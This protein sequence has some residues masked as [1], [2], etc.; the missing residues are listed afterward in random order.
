MVIEIV[1]KFTGSLKYL[2][3]APDKKTY[4]RVESFQKRK[5]TGKKIENEK[6]R[7]KSEDFVAR[8]E[9]I[10]SRPCR[11]LI[12]LVHHIISP[13]VIIELNVKCDLYI[14]VCHRCQDILVKCS[15]RAKI[16]TCIVVIVVGAYAFTEK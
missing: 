8:L 12:P 16:N 1:K 11:Y 2:I 4:F 7:K 5:K 13:D 10:K 3:F 9:N 15:G 6:E 14:V